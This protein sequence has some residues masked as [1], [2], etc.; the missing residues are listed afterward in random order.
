M[1]YLQVFDPA[2]NI[3]NIPDL[4]LKHL[5][6]CSCGKCNY[7]FANDDAWLIQYLS[8]HEC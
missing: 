8:S 2:G 1:K 5:Y 4:K 7:Y 6:K 3:H